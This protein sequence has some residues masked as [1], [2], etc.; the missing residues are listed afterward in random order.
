M[1][2]LLISGVKLPDQLSAAADPGFAE[3]RFHMILYGIGGDVED[4][5]QLF[6]GPS[7]RQL[8]DDFFLAFCEAVRFGNQRKEVCGLGCCKRNGKLDQA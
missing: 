5:R 7:L 4:L 8:A 3:D 1:Y 2:R 6:G